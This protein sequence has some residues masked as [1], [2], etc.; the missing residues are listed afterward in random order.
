[1]Q[2]IDTIKHILPLSLK[3]TLHYRWG[4]HTSSLIK[5]ESVDKS[6]LIISFYRAIQ[7]YRKKFNAGNGRRWRRPIPQKI[8]LAVDEVL[9]NVEKSG[10]KIDQSI[11]PTQVEFWAVLRLMAGGHSWTSRAGMISSAMSKIITDQSLSDEFIK[12]A[13]A[14]FSI[15]NSRHGLRDIFLNTYLSIAGAQPSKPPLPKFTKTLMEEFQNGRNINLKIST[16]CARL[17]KA[18]SLSPAD[19][20]HI[21]NHCSAYISHAKPHQSALVAINKVLTNLHPPEPPIEPRPHLYLF[22]GAPARH[23]SGAATSAGLRIW[24][25]DKLRMELPL[26]ERYNQH[27]ILILSA[28][29][30]IHS[31]IDQKSTNSGNRWTVE[32]RAL[33]IEK[34]N[35]C[36]KTIEALLKSI[37]ALPQEKVSDILSSEPIRK[38]VSIS[39]NG[40]IIED[41]DAVN[42]FI[43]HLSILETA[44]TKSPTKRRLGHKL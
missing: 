28:I 44:K 16:Y 23:K 15:I 21:K 9:K 8:H 35:H 3:D 37:K 14:I 39:R 34:N 43:S 29:L 2:F 33:I 32:N 36:R 7:G 6:P 41:R 27:Q 18:S 38:A 5:Q 19:I 42:N 10:E 30:L 31:R 24:H 20:P 25:L 11:N 1:M 12:N 4:G 17:I 40:I 13:D 22:N 26:G